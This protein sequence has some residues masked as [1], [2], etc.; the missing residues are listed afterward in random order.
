M[1]FLQIPIRSPA[2]QIVWS[3]SATHLILGVI[4]P[5]HF[6]LLAGMYRISLAA[7]GNFTLSTNHGDA[8]A[9][10]VFVD[11]HSERTRLLH[12]KCKVRRIDFIQIA[13]PQFTHAE[14]HRAL[15][16]PVLQDIFVQIQEG[17]R[18]HAAQVQ[19][20]L[21]SLQLGARILIGPQF[22]ANRHWAILR[23]GC[24]I[25]GSSGLKGYISVQ[26]TNARDP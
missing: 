15:G 16:N 4:R 8:R 18:S 24:P 19:R 7:S 9:V 26:I 10:P 5:V 21:A 25:F 1:L 12:R 20:R 23:R 6:R 14:V 2:I 22:V 13:F 17:K 3:R 11:I